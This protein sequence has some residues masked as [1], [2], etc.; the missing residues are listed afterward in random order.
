MEKAPPKE[1]HIIIVGKQVICKRIAESSRAVIERAL[2]AY[3][4]GVKKGNTG[5]I[6][7]NLNSIKMDLLLIRRRKRI[8]KRR[9]KKLGKGLSL[10]PNKKE[11]MKRSP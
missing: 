8:K 3:A 1:S 5:R 10:A 7:V 4:P 6:N 2:Q 9:V 11:S